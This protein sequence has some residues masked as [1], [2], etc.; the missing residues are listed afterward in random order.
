MRNRYDR[1][2]NIIKVTKGVSSI[3]YH[4]FTGYPIFGIFRNNF[5]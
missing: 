4:D 3:S 2:E 5:H 1:F